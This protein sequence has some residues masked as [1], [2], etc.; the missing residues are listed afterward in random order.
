MQY[1]L[2]CV[3]CFKVWSS[4]REV[5]MVDDVDTTLANH[6]VFMRHHAYDVEVASTWDKRANQIP[7]PFGSDTYFIL[8]LIR[9]LF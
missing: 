2:Y 1:V 7:S 3:I 8:I 9:V 5:F 6:K 4:N